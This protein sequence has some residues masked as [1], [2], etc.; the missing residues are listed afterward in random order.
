[1]APTWSLTA[2]KGQSSRFQASWPIS[3]AAEAPSTPRN[4]TAVTGIAT[5]T[6]PRAHLPESPPG[7]SRQDC[8]HRRSSGDQTQAQRGTTTGLSLHLH[9][10]EAPH[11]I[12]TRPPG[13]TVTP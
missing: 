9:L 1:M 11:P 6:L 7:P 2:Q 3:D 5:L 4:N 10:S 12:P 8:L 13:A